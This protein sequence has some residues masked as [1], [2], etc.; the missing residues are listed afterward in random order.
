[1]KTASLHGSAPHTE[2]H[3]YDPTTGKWKTLAVK[4]QSLEEI[5][6]PIWKRATMNDHLIEHYEPPK[7]E[8]HWSELA[9]CRNTDGNIFYINEINQ[10]A[11][12]LARHTCITCPV[13][14][15]CLQ[16]SLNNEPDQF[17][18]LA[19]YLPNE[20]FALKRR[21]NS[22]KAVGASS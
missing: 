17:A 20:R 14:L 8:E 19:G 10:S 16:Q 5:L 18:V 1:M 6:N 12:P 11:L 7:R 22:R 2:E 3:L 4:H 21:I 15:D 9:L 13:R